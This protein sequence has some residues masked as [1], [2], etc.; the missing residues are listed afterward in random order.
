MKIQYTGATKEQVQWG[1]NTDP[2]NI[3]IE[4][5]MYELDNVEVHSYHTKIALK[6]VKGWFNSASFTDPEDPEDTWLEPY[7]EQYAKD[8]HFI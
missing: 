3:L 5:C 1:N 8:Q 6:G 7:F 2:R 4:G